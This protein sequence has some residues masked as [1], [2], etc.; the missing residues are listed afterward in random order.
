MGIGTVL[1]LLGRRRDPW[2][3]H[4]A[5]EGHAEEGGGIDWS[6]GRCDEVLALASAPYPQLCL[7]RG[8][9]NLAQEHQNGHFCCFRPLRL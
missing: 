1:G 4:I 9:V 2:W 5:Q 8:Y 3:K 6:R 7:H